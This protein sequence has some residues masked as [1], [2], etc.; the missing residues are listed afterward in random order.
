VIDTCNTFWG[1]HGCE[2]PTGHTPDD[3]HP[4]HECSVE[5]MDQDGDIV[6]RDVCSQAQYVTDQSIR[7]RYFID[8]GRWTDWSE[9]ALPLFR[10]DEEKAR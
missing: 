7:T 2:L 5:V 3:E 10:R 9:V 6:G 4:I 1:S 8:D